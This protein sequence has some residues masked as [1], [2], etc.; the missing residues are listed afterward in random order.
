MHNTTLEISWSNYSSTTPLYSTAKIKI[1]DLILYQVS[2]TPSTLGIWR[3][4][5]FD[6]SLQPSLQVLISGIVLTVVAQLSVMRPNLPFALQKHTL[7]TYNL[8]LSL[9]TKTNHIDAFNVI[10]H[11]KHQGDLPIILSKATISPVAP[12][13]PSVHD[14]S[15]LAWFGRLP[16]IIMSWTPRLRRRVSHTIN[17]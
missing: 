15:L 2:A 9:I 17:A 11:V 12:M 8:M 6:S 10:P 1:E 4:S 16:C 13:M 7:V 14:I 5:S 3:H